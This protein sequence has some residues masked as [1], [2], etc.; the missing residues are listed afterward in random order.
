MVRLFALLLALMLVSCGGGGEQPSAPRGLQVE[1]IAGAGSAMPSE[2]RAGLEQAIPRRLAAVAG[3]ALS[4]DEALN[5]AESMYP[6]LF[7]RSSR[8]VRFESPYIYRYYSS[9][10]NYL[11]VSTTSTDVAVFLYGPYSGWRLQRIGSL[12]DF[13]CTIKPQSCVIAA[14]PG[15]LS[16][17]AAPGGSQQVALNISLPP[18]PGVLGARVASV[19]PVSWLATQVTGSTTVQVTASASGMPAG[20]YDAE[21]LVTYTP[22]VGAPITKTVPLTFSVGTGII[23]SGS[24]TRTLDAVATAQSLSGSITLSGI[25]GANKAWTAASSASWLV[26]NTTSGTTPST[27]NYSV[28]ATAAA[29]LANFSEHTAYIDVSA[30]GAIP[31]RVQVS[32]DKRLPYLKAVMPYGIPAGSTS[33]VVVR[34]VGLSQF[35]SAPTIGGLTASNVQVQSDS[36]MSF[37]VT[38][39]AAGTYNLTV[40]NAAG[41]A[42][43]AAALK[44]AAADPYR[45]GS[46]AVTGYKTTAIHDPVRQAIFV[47]GYGENALYKYQY[48]N[49]TWTTTALAISQPDS[50]GLSP[51]GSRLFVTG[52]SSSIKEVNP[53]TMTVTATHTAPFTV[54]INYDTPLAVTV[55]SRLWIPGGYYNAMTYLDLADNAFK[56]VSVPSSVDTAAYVGLADGATALVSP[57]FCCSNIRWHLY[58]AAD[59]AVTN[60]MGDAQFWYRLKVNVDGSRILQQA[61][62]ELYGGNYELLGQL[63]QNATDEHYGRVA[64]TPDGTRII[65][66]V[67]EGNYSATYKRIDVFSTSTYQSGTTRF[68]KIGSMSVSKQATNCEN[69]DSYY[70]TTTG[71]LLPSADSKAVFWIG[72][73]W[74]QVFKLP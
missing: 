59:G 55:D 61:T 24:Q 34:G 37:E 9:T 19:P 28:D 40:N 53:D 30:G 47:V 57:D 58:N 67:Y 22:Q 32:L 4:V 41:V 2:L 43:A 23:A 51:D 46:V 18:M 3:T 20:N 69:Y 16:M 39:E 8:L 44:V 45:S 17:G 25:D 14:T 11:G 1:A 68:A 54:G 64:L 27:L 35:A 50:V 42:T 7:P 49:G 29:G 70:C 66:L 33:R 31:A 73:Q 36:Q 5:W 74:L 71:V 12:T 62:G 72:N 10:Q 15:S 26:V 65:A 6:D 52:Q 21:V 38:P 13:T 48:A 56:Q 63:P 60:P